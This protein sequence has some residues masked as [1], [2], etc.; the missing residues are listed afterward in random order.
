MGGAQESKMRL[1]T[2]QFI[3]SPTTGTK[4]E[5]EPLT[6]ADNDMLEERLNGKPISR[7][8]PS[9]VVGEAPE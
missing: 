9:A 2:A 7:S 8:V 1:E 3:R 4:V 6:F 5:P